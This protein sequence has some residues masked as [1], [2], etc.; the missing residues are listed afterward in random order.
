M[1]PRDN[2][3]LWTEPDDHCDKLAVYRA[4]VNLT[5]D[6]LSIKTVTDERNFIMRLLYKDMYW[7]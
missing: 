6:S 5:D 4:V 3:V 2:I 1:D 7:V